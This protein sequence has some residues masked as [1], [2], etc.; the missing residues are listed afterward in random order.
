MENGE[1]GSEIDL[2]K[3]VWFQSSVSGLWYQNHDLATG[4]VRVVMVDG[5]AYFKDGA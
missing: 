1:D 4:S 5:R 2:T 3:G